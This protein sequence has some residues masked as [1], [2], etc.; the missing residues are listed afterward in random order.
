LIPY[1]SFISFLHLRLVPTVH[2]FINKRGGS[3]DCG[4]EI[5][6]IRTNQMRDKT[7]TRSRHSATSPHPSHHIPPS[8][9]QTPPLASSLPSHTHP[10]P[11]PSPPHHRK[12][13]HAIMSLSD[14]PD[15]C[16]ANLLIRLC[17]IVLYAHE[18]ML[19][20]LDL[21]EREFPPP[22]YHVVG[23]TFTFTASASSKHPEPSHS[24][25][26]HI[27]FSKGDSQK[28]STPMTNR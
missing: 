1:T 3:E 18:S 5:I 21:P 17:L 20:I 26:M 9:K 15:E 6:G 28:I 22:Q 10:S 8:S 25:P 23:N 24:F 16:I 4:L 11:S 2:L 12:P 19:P 27:L 7:E 13:D 14:N